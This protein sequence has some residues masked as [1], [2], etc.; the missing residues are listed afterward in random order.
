MRILT[1]TSN[2]LGISWGPAIHYLELWNALHAIAPQFT[3]TGFA[4]S[5]T[6]SS[7][8]I[9]NAFPLR[10]L[11]VSNIPSIRQLIF[12]ARMSVH[13]FMRGGQYD[14]VYI[15]LSH[16]HVL[17]TAALKLLRIPYVLE[18]NGLA[19]EDSTSSRKS[20]FIKRI[21][22]QQERWL[23]ENAMLCIAVSEGIANT[24][25]RK[26]TLQGEIV[27]IGN[28]VARQFFSA[29][30]SAQPAARAPVVIYVGTFTAWDGAAEVVKLAQ[31]FPDVEFLMVGDGGARV[32]LEKASTANV[33]FIGKVHYNELPALYASADAAIVL[34]EYERHRNVKV[35][36]LKTL[37][38]VASRLPVFTTD[39]P[40]QEFI[41]DNGY[42]V[43]VPQG[44]DL[45]QSFAQFIAQRNTYAAN[46]KHSIESMYEQFGWKR[47]AHETSVAL[48][49]ISP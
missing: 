6:K 12:D 37:E 24:L 26:Y 44:A 49:L 15:R 8:V 22:C 11:Q 23:V 48:S 10:T 18:L 4:P 38:Y 25:A 35:S 39:I 17:Q 45:Q 36:S 2:D 5:W 31:S 33:K 30:R 32:Q 47:T 13:L 41:Q 9:D 27:T 7:P 21:I 19:E 34:Y 3:I 29:Q 40:G 20:G 28:G 46:Y 43:L 16:W 42:G 14:L 1:I